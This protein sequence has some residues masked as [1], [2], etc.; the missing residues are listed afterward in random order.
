MI[1]PTRTGLGLSLSERVAGWTA[2]EVEI[3][4]AS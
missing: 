4:K 3:T 2:Q 1:V